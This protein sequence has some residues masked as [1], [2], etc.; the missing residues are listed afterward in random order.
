LQVCPP[1]LRRARK[2]RVSEVLLVVV[3]GAAVFGRDLHV[4]IADHAAELLDHRLDL[5]DLTPALL[6]LESLHANLCVS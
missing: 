1:L 6:D 3:A 4:E 5:A 2:R